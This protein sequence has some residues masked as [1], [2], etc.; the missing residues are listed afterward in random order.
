MSNPKLIITRSAPIYGSTGIFCP[1]FG[2]SFQVSLDSVFQA[3]LDLVF[4]AF[5]DLVFQA[6]LDLVFQAFLDLVFQAFL[7]HGV[8]GFSGSGVPGFLDLV[9]QV[10]WIW[11]SRFSGSVFQVFWITVFLGLVALNDSICLILLI[12]LHLSFHL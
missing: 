6:F 4:Q 3:F 1:V 10:F 7:D 12:E 5:L 8:P 11:C 9:F 2:N